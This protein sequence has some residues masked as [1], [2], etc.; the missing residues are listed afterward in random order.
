M[1]LNDVF[2]VHPVR[3]DLQ[4]HLRSAPCPFL[5]GVFA[6]LVLSLRCKKQKVSYHPHIPQK[7]CISTYHL[8][9]HDSL[10]SLS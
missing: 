9:V 8:Q 4:S 2:E 1:T 7:V 10:L 5:Q 3:S 6:F